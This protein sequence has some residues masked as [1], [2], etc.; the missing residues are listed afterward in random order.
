MEGDRERRQGKSDKCGERRK[1]MEREIDLESNTIEK[2]VKK[3]EV[4]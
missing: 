2:E 3:K 4:T 1:E